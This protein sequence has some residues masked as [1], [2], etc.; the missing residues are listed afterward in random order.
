MFFR[1]QLNKKHFQSYQRWLQRL[2]NQQCE[3]AISL[4]QYGTTRCFSLK[5]ETTQVKEICGIFAPFESRTYDLFADFV[6]SKNFDDQADSEAAVDAMK[7]KHGKMKL[8][9]SF[10]EIHSRKN[11]C[12]FRMTTFP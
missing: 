7:G 2:Q 10:L 9:L 1:L 11:Q 3:E 12:T 8:L 4:V 6:Q 5:S